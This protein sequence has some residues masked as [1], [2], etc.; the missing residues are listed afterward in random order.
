MPDARVRLTVTM[1]QGTAPDISVAHD[2]S[3]L[4]TVDPLPAAGAP[5]LLRISSIRIDERRPL[6][7]GKTAQYINFLL[8]AAEARDAGADDALLL[9]H[10]GGICEAT[11]SNV[12]AVRH[13]VLL[14]PSTRDGALPGVTATP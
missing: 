12:F 7:A 4:V 13:G 11:T 6:A 2:P 8:A 14:T 10:R 3:V 5:V 9:N 1:G